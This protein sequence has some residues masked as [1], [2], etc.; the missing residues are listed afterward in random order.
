MIGKPDEDFAR[1][2]LFD[3]RALTL[4]RFSRTDMLARRTPDFKVL[5]EERLV[6]FCEAKSPR[7]DWL[8]KQIEAVAPGQIGGGVRSDPTLNRI[9]RHIEK[10]ASQFDAVNKDHALPN[11]LV[12]VNHANA[13]GQADLLETITGTFFAED[14]R[15]IP[16][17]RHISE[18]RIGKTRMAVDLYIWIDRKKSIPHFLFN[19][20]SFVTPLCDLLGLDPTKI[21]N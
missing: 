1:K 17:V 3:D 16:T 8:D 4:Q 6:A 10:A 12:F 18:G 9:A 11:I 2:L 5:K 19:R 13:A 7:D 20:T 15:R 21:T 14:G